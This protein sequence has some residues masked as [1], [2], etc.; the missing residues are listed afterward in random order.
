MPT[1]SEQKA[2]AFV[3]LVILLGGVVRVVRGGALATPAPTLAE[4]QALARQAFAANS[5]AVDGRASVRRKGKK[6]RVVTQE[7]RDT[8]ANRLPTGAYNVP[9]LDTRGFP[10]PYPRIDTD[11]GSLRAK[12][13]PP[14][15]TLERRTSPERRGGPLDL[16]T[17]TEQEID[18][19]PYVGP[20]LARRIVANRDSLG[21][22]GALAA[23][24]RVRGI[25]PA[26][27]ERL[28]SLVTFSGQTRR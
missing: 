20:S 24:R 16:D 11:A 28:G 7:R 9:A 8:G 15:L 1:P 10:P 12:P 23:L 4:Q 18:A 13:T 14:P 19:L 25:G 17:A 27:L 6:S 21:P 26:T 2:L 3:A 5:S 22:F